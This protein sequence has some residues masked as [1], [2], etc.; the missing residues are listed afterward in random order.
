MAS[1]CIPIGHLGKLSAKQTDEL[2][3]E[4]VRSTPYLKAPLPEGHNEK[5]VSK[6]D[7][8]FVFLSYSPKTTAS[9]IGSMD[10]ML[11]V[12]K[13]LRKPT[14]PSRLSTSSENSMVAPAGQSFMVI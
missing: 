12:T 8:P 6:L 5:G 10:A 9:P 4:S 2:F 13:A 14:S 1:L 7:T 3:I 11:S